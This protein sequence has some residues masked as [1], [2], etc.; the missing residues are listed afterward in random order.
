M[1]ILIVDD[2]RRF[3]NLERAFLKRVDCEILTAQT[4][5]EA[6]KVATKEKP[7][8]ICLDIEM[9]EMNGIEVVRY[10]RAQPDYKDIPIIVISA[11]SRVDEALEAG[12]HAF[13]Q[14]P[15]DEKTFLDALA[16]YLDLR[17]R[18]DERKE[19]GVKCRFMV[20]HRDAYHSG[21]VGNISVSGMYLETSYPMDIGD[22]VIVEFEMPMNDVKKYIQAEG[23]IVRSDG[24]GF[25][26]RFTNISEGAKLF[27]EEYVKRKEA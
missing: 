20:Q 15:I 11:T 14:K 23:I 8:I 13:Y 27:I 24:R 10:L 26:I 7:D 6:I 12:A 9:P 18:Q 17:V 16:R 5:L 3:L 1:K 21:I 4:G 25:G 22:E 19:L 2:M